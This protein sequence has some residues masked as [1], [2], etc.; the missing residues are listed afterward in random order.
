MPQVIEGKF[1]S[2]LK[3]SEFYG[4]EPR[5][6]QRWVKSE[7]KNRK[8]RAIVGDSSRS[9]DEHMRY[10]ITSVLA[11]HLQSKSGLPKTLI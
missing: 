10:S 1:R 7:L 8:G 6:V 3:A 9:E 11:I 2:S 4:L 5:S